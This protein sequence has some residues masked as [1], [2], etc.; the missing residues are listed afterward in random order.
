MSERSQAEEDAE[1]LVNK[2]RKRSRK[3]SPKQNHSPLGSPTQSARNSEQI[4]A[5]KI[6]AAMQANDGFG[7]YDRIEID[8]SDG[9]RFRKSDHGARIQRRLRMAMFPLSKGKKK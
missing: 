2:V 8:W 3:Y 5:G 6:P 7:N 4:D 1:K 9:R